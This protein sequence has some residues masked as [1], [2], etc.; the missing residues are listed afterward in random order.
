MEFLDSS[1]VFEVRSPRAL[2]GELELTICAKFST[3]MLFMQISVEFKLA[4]SL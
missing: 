3:E 2:K 4:F 1:R